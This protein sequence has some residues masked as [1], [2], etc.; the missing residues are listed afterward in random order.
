MIPIRPMV[1]KPPRDVRS[2]LV[3]IPYMLHATK[4]AA[5]IKKDIV[6]VITKDELRKNFPVYN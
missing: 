3:V 1:M 5:Q 2:R 6:V 4:V